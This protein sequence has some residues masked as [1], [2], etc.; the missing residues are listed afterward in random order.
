MKHFRIHTVLE[1]RSWYLSGKNLEIYSE[2][3]EKYGFEKKGI[4]DVH[5]S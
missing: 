3:I 2:S 4:Y 1:R 5:A